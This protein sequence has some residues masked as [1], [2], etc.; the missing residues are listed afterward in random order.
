MKKTLIILITLVLSI[1][2]YSAAVSSTVDGII[3]YLPS[4]GQTVKKGDVLVKFDTVSVE[5]QIKIT[6]LELECAKEDYDDKCSDFQRMKKLIK[7]L[8]RAAQ[9]DVRVAYHS[10]R[11]SLGKLKVVLADLESTKSDHKILA[12]CNLII[13]EQ[14]IVP[15]SG[16]ELGEAI[17]EVESVNSK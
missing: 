9:E 12:P 7:V 11:V 2:V 5:N 8:S 14:L 3:K 17:L 13:K 10:S 15:N 16:V 1:G 4:K 6:K